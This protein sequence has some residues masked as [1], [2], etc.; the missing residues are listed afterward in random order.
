[1]SRASFRDPR[2]LSQKID[3]CHVAVGSSA[4]SVFMYVL[5]LKVVS[6]YACHRLILFVSRQPEERSFRSLLPL[7]PNFL[8]IFRIHF[9]LPR[10]STSYNLPSDEPRARFHR[11]IL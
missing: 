8:D 4:D 3:S 7:L 6:L 11:R 1:M 9:T 10:A 2:S 5:N